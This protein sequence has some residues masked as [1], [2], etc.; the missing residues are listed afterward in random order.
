MTKIILA[1][2]LSKKLDGRDFII[3]D[4]EKF[5]IDLK[6]GDNSKFITINDGSQDYT[7]NKNMIIGIEYGCASNNGAEII[8]IKANVIYDT[9]RNV[10]IEPSTLRD[11]NVVKGINEARKIRGFSELEY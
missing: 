4:S 6:L 11:K 7:I 5:E 2:E 3:T 8:N 1:K 10:V 9:N